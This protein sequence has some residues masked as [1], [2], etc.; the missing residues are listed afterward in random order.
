MVASFELIE[1]TCRCESL[2]AED[3]SSVQGMFGW[4]AKL[5]HHLQPSMNLVLNHHLSL[6][7]ILLGRQTKQLA[8][9]NDHQSTV[10]EMDA[11]VKYISDQ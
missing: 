11:P 8:Q 1:S 3:E 5:P 7:T 10:F 2:G 4:T 9:N 6:E